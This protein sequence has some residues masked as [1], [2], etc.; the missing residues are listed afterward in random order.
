M[1]YKYSRKR[2]EATT[3]DFALFDPDGKDFKDNAS[4]VAG[5]V[6][7]MKDEGAEGNTT[8]LPTDE[9]QGYSLV[10]DATEMS[11][12][13]IAIYLADGETKT[14]LDEYI[15]IETYGTSSAM[16]S[17]NLD[18]DFSYE[19]ERIYLRQLKIMNESNDEPALWVRS[20]GSDG[21]GAIIESA[22]SGPGMQIFGGKAFS[23]NGLEI[24]GGNTG[25]KGVAIGSQANNDNALD[26]TAHGTG[27]DID[28]KEIDTLLT[29]QTTIEGKIDIID[30]NV[31]AILA[32]LIVVDSNVDAIL[33]LLN[34]VDGKID[35]ID[36]NVDSILGLVT[37]IDGKIDIIDTNLDA[38]LALLGT[39][40]GKVDIID[41]NVD[42]ILALV[43]TLDT[44]LS[45]VLALLTT[46]D[47]KIDIVD[48]NVDLIVAKLPA[49]TI[50]DLA[51]TDTIDG[52]TFSKILE[53][54]MC[55]FNGN[56]D[57]DDPAPGQR[58]FFKR[59][60]VTVLSVIRVDDSGRERIS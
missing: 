45:S 4:F 9:G 17:F 26:L 22:Q 46:V 11:A 18:F 41:T 28:A 21:I 13:R 53:Y 23:G 48:S 20:E 27:K 2:G 57:E 6:K 15:I 31:D 52:V 30:T 24:L 12:K 25:G 47:G 5:D 54:C 55:M 19:T 42:A 59:N 1:P 3:I 33:A 44:D 39:V 32:G 60:G 14:W 34:V 35:I 58:T 10:L 40:D 16:H 37:T 8:N 56:F 36:T 43:T 51:L 7:I 29:G 38:T 50:S 49:G